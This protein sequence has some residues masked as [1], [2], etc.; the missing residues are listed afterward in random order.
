[1]NKCYRQEEDKKREGAE[2]MFREGATGTLT[3]RA[4]WAGAIESTGRRAKLIASSLS[5]VLSLSSSSV[6][7]RRLRSSNNNWAVTQLA[8]SNR[9]SRILLSDYVCSLC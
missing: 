5:F 4:T 2:G 7:Y 3:G 9:N 8:T 1:M 6:S